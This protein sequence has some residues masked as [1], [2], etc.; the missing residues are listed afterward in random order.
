MAV[1][2]DKVHGVAEKL[3]NLPSTVSE[4]IQE[5]SECDHRKA[6]YFNTL[7]LGDETLFYDAS[8]LGC[9]GLAT[10]VGVTQLFEIRQSFDKFD[11]GAFMQV[12]EQHFPGL[13]NISMI[14]FSFRLF[15]ANASMVGCQNW[16][17]LPSRPKAAVRLAYF[18]W[19]VALSQFFGIGRLIPWVAPIDISS[20][21]T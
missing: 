5:F 7:A 3:V 11:V 20:R 18:S 21:L 14:I 4:L 1:A 13:A 16:T 19:G 8:Y 17:C 6:L 12:R 15:H 2:Y 9:L 10:A